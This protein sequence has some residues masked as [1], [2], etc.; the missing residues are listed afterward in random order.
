MTTTSRGPRLIAIGRMKPGPERALFEQH[1]ARLRPALAVTEL[2]EAQGAN[3]AE[4]RRREGAALLAALPEAAFAVALD[5]GGAAPTT[6]ALAALVTRWDEA[7]RP[8]CYLIG[9]TEGLDQAVLD[10]ADHRLS[11]GSLTWPHFLVRGLLAEQLFRVQAIRTNHPYHRA[12][13]PA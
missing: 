3:P 4:I 13:R 8:V 5:L 1:A 9:G 6:E 11:L 10:R 12:W 2:A 7:A